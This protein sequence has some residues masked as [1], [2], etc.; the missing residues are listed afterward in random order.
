M[1]KQTLGK[2]IVLTFPDFEKPFEIYTDASKVQ[3]GAVIEQE[4]KPLAFYSRK[5]NDA[6]TRYTVTELARTTFFSR[7]LAGILYHPAWSHRKSIYAYERK[8]SK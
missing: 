6:Q 3:L 2:N 5:L 7:D 8:P 1:V 4:G